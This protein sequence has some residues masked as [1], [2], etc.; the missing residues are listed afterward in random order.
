MSSPIDFDDLDAGVGVAGP[1]TGGGSRTGDAVVPTRRR[2]PVRAWIALSVISVALGFVLFNGLGEATLFFRPVDKAVAERAQLGTKRFT[3]EGLVVV[4][5]VKRQDRSVSF[6]IE[7]N[8]VTVA[9]D[10][11]GIPPELFREDL[12]VVLDG[13]FTAATGAATF[14]SDRMMVKHGSDYVT[15]NPD[16]V[17]DYTKTSLK[18][19]VKTD[20]K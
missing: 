9:V 4:G 11:A 5:S 16:R 15:K 12:P 14:K 1:P 17:K 7:N 10:H 6:Q 19:S 18:T 8:G 3:I 13:R 20:A 2:S